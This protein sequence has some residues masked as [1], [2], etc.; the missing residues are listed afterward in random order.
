M[1]LDASSSS[2][3][4]GAVYLPTGQLTLNGGSS[5]AAY[6]QIFANSVMVDSAISLSGGSGGVANGSTTI[7][8]AE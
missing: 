8:L 1:N 4:G 6:G 2:S 7:A 3:F 5:S